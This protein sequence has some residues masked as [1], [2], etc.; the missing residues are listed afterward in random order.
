ME[1]KNFEIKTKLLGGFTRDVGLCEINGNVA[2]IKSYGDFK[3]RFVD[4]SKSA[5]SLFLSTPRISFLSVEER[6][7]R[8]IKGHDKLSDLGIA[9]PKILDFSVKDGFIVE[10][11]VDG[12][13][14]HQIIKD[15]EKERKSISFEIGKL[16]GYL[17]SKGFAFFDNRP[18]NYI[19]KDGKIFRIDLETFETSPSKFERYCDVISFTESFVGRTRDDVHDSFI[20]GYECY[21]KHTHNK[22]IET[23]ARRAL[24]LLNFNMPSVRI[25]S[26]FHK[27]SISSYGNTLGSI[28]H[29]LAGHFRKSKSH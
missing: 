16:T 10:E 13:N 2:V 3:P 24:F 17:H 7:Q 4:F 19:F 6:I 23:L 29:F 5:F 26:L 9:V 8:E 15:S 18:Q 27:D 12:K 20:A 21:S 1:A 28:K 22:F 11:F 14:L 25:G